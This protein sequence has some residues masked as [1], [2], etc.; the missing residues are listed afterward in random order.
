MLAKLHSLR[1][2]KLV[3]P[4]CIC[5]LHIRKQCN[6]DDHACQLGIRC[7]QLY[8]RHLLG[9]GQSGTYKVD[10]WYV[11]EGTE[12]TSCRLPPS[13]SPTSLS[14]TIKFVASRL[15]MSSGRELAAYDARS[16]KSIVAVTPATVAKSED[17]ERQLAHTLQDVKAQVAELMLSMR[18]GTPK[19]C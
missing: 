2:L 19:V 5:S 3:Q 12:L 8:N 16:S 6:A 7:S 15:S 17:H 9:R 18:N 11:A 1:N 14:S 10:T 4:P 13:S